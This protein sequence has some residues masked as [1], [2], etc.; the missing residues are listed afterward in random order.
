MT[1][2]RWTSWFRTRSEWIADLSV[3]MRCR[4]S[5]LVRRSVAALVIGSACIPTGRP[6]GVSGTPVDM[7]AASGSDVVVSN[8]GMVA[9][10][11]TERTCAKLKV[12]VREDSNQSWT[13]LNNTLPPSPKLSRR[14]CQPDR[15]APLGTQLASEVSDRSH[16]L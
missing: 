2:S 12:R 3:E 5:S 16:A 10:N 11:Q 4:I 1:F 14:P 7:L 9:V 6:P 8:A 13:R 15:A